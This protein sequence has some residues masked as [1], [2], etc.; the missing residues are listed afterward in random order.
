MSA[1]ASQI[2]GVS[3]ACLTACSGTDQ[4]EHQISSSLAFMGESTG[5]WWIHLTK[6]Q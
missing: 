1:M 3:I 5:V 2:T 6:G 4:R